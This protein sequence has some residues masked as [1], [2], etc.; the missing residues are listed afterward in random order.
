MGNLQLQI[1]NVPASTTEHNRA[2]LTEFAATAVA[3]EE[4]GAVSDWGCVLKLPKDNE[5]NEVLLQS[6][7]LVTHINGSLHT[8]PHALI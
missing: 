1:H 8:H 4:G 2:L 3:Q 5:C 6:R 7:Q